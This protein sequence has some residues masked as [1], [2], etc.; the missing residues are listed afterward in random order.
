MINW[1]SVIFNSFWIFGLSLLLAAFSYHTWAASQFGRLLRVQLQETSFLRPLW[2]SIMLVCIGL[3]GTSNQLW[4]TVV[5]GIMALFALFSF[6]R[7]FPN[8]QT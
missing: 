4:E 2:V 6:A 3:S 7:L 5:W 1:Q 8:L